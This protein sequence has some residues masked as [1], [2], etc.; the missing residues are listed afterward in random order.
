MIGGLHLVDTHHGGGH[1]YLGGGCSELT[2]CPYLSTTKKTWREILFPF[3][4]GIDIT[5]LCLWNDRSKRSQPWWPQ[6]VA[7]IAREQILEDIHLYNIAIIMMILF[8]HLL[9][10]LFYS[11][12]CYHV[13]A[14][15]SLISYITQQRRSSSEITNHQQQHHQPFFTTSTSHHNDNNND[16]VV[17]SFKS[18]L[19]LHSSST[20]ATMRRRELQQ[21]TTM[22]EGNCSGNILEGGQQ[23]SKGSYLW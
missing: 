18:K 12:C 8:Y 11:C 22:M 16:E 6:V 23:R 13:D 9:L 10:L 4:T 20:T 15:P 2:N 14:E 21:Q 3:I 19:H 5:S 1:R 7:A 17:H